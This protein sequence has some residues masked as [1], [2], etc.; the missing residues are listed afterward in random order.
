M[1]DWLKGLPGRVADNV[2]ASLIG[3]AILSA[4]ALGW[5]SGAFEA[6]VD[7]DASLPAWVL[8][9]GIMAVFALGGFAGFFLNRR[10]EADPVALVAHRFWREAD[11]HAEYAEH[12]AL[13]LDQLQNVLAGAIPGVTPEH[14]IERGVLHPGRDMLMKNQPRGADVRLSVLVPDGAEFVMAYS[15]GHTPEGHARFRMRIAESFSRHAYEQGTIVAS[16]DVEQDP[17]FKAHP[18]A[19]RNYRSIVSVPLRSGEDTAGVFNVVFT[20]QEAFDVSEYTYIALL[21]AITNVALTAL[22]NSGTVRVDRPVQSALPP[23]QEEPHDQ[24]PP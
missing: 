6:V 2:I 24:P 16:P 14:F 3:A 8:A 21:A 4:A 9:A 20:E 18:R 17:R 11:L 1:S 5:I 10:R 22:E 13:T 7:G 19:T 23:A 12:V 15:A